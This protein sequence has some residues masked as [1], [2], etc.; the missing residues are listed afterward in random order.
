LSTSFSFDVVVIG[1]GVVGSS[2][3]YFLAAEQAFDGSVA[4]V[5]RDP[6]YVDGSTARSV[7]GIRSQFSTPENVEIS[8]FGA[9]FLR[10]AAETLAV[11]GERGDVDFVEA[12]YLLLASAEGLDVLR[13]NH[14]VQRAHGAAVDLLDP[15]EL[16][17]R[18]PWLHTAD[19]AAGSLG[20]HGEG[21]IDA[22]SLLMALRRKARSLGVSYV[23]GEAVGVRRDGGRVTSVGLADGRELR[24]AHVVNAAGPRAATVAALAGVPDLPV[25]SKKRFVF[26]VEC[27]RPLP[28][29]PLVVDYGGVYFRPE[30]DRFVCGI[31]PPRER[32]ADCED[33]K[34][35]PGFFE[36]LVW[37]ALAHRVPAMD[38]LEVRSSWAGHYAYNVVDQNAVL[39][40]HPEVSNFYFAN[41][42]SGH[43]LQQAPAVGRALAELITYGEYRTLDLRRFRFERFAAGE[44]VRE[45]N[46]I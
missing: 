39:G 10:A 2:I 29:C 12:G 3:A 40:P 4:V 36:E 38:E 7:G 21:W 17:E 43:G 9:R 26:T 33:L 6:T 19:L 13:A 18:F 37:P 23:R 32:D 25:R 27:P 22:Y 8:R 16:A 42:F 44:L 41:G 31:S 15:G 5:E 11:G 28:G 14:E 24:A 35:D 46:V 30:G 1:G 34:L 45:R 20:L